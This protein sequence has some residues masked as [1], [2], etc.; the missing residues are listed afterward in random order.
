MNYDNYK[1]YIS[2]KSFKIIKILFLYFFLSIIYLFFSDTL[3]ESTISLYPAGELSD[4]NS[5]LSELSDYT[6]TFGVNFSNKSNYYIPDIIHSHSLKKEII[7]KEWF[8]SK[9]NDSKNLI[10]Y[11]EINK[12]SF[13]GTIINVIKAPFRNKYYNQQ[14]DYM[15]IAIKKLDELI[16]VNEDYSGLI[17]VNVLFEDPQIAAD[18]ANFISEYVINFVNAEQK[19]FASKTTKHLSIKCNVFYNKVTKRT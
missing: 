10:E 14:L 5:V 19:V 7:S 13:F 6:E 18:I 4:N 2:S 17:Q 3:Y 11:W 8:S 1:Q 12:D 9:Y 16:S 15:N